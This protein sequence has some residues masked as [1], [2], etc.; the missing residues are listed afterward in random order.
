M[1]SQENSFNS[2][3]SKSNTSGVKGVV[4]YKRDKR[5]ETRIKLNGKQKQIGNYKTLEEAKQARISTAKEVFGN[6]VNAFEK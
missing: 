3:L 6:Y 4:Y 1:T 5:W 2:S